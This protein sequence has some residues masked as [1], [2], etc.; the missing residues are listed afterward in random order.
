[1]EAMRHLRLG[2]NLGIM[3]VNVNA[4]PLGGIVCWKCLKASKAKELRHACYAAEI[5]PKAVSPGLSR[6]WCS[7]R[8]LAHKLLTENN[9]WKRAS[10]QERRVRL[11][12]SEGESTGRL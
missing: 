7:T 1:M 10:S 8:E 2:D 9:L 3:L 4:I 11:F 12:R 5:C 6:R